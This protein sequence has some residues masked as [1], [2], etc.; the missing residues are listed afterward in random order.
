MLL[1]LVEAEGRKFVH[2]PIVGQDQS[3]DQIE[4]HDLGQVP[5]GLALP[6]HPPV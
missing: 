6:L 1:L 2:I 3:V 5:W 4:P